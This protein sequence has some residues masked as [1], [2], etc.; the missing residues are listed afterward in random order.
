MAHECVNAGTANNF[1]VSNNNEGDEDVKQ[2][3]EIAQPQQLKSDF[4]VNSQMNNPIS[5]PLEQGDLPRSHSGSLHASCED[6]VTTVIRRWTEET[7]HE[8][9]RRQREK[10]NVTNVDLT[11]KLS[12]PGSVVQEDHIL[13]AP[14]IQLEE[15]SPMS[16]Q[17]SCMSLDLNLNGV[18]DIDRDQQEGPSLVLM[19]CRDCHLYVMA[20]EINPICPRCKSC[21]YLLDI[22]RG[23]LPQN[24]TKG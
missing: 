2:E 23:N 4:D 17:H 20:S 9:S 6:G 1:S 11:L 8:D 14:S 5:T 7:C 13:H 22:F 12:P 10:P 21:E 16:S 3:E 18:S 24:M 15:P 19:G